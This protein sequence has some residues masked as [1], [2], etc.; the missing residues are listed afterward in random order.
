MAS[1]AQHN[2]DCLKFLDESFENVNRW[3]DD[4][5]NQYGPTHRKFRHHREG[6]EE[7]RQIF[8]DR[9]ATAAAIHV[10]RDCR[11]IP[12]KQDYDLGYVDALG[13]KRSWSTTAYIGYSQED[14]ESL[15]DQLLKPSALVLWSFID[16]PTVQLFLSSLTRLQ[17]KEIEG[18]TVPWQEANTKRKLLP[19]LDQ[20]SPQLLSEE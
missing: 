9:A 15:V 13:L 3:M 8:G 4:Y 19:P 16:P 18:L 11:Q 14:F 2:S 6:I 20:T 1:L 12:R 17:P 5:F 7:A 10:L